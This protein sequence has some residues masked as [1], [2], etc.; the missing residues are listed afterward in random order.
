MGSHLRTLAGDNKEAIERLER[1][2]SP[3]FARIP[4]TCQ[5]TCGD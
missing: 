4:T 5:T 3:L 2:L 1:R